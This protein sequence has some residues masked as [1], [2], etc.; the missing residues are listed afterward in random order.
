MASLAEYS[1]KK[2][3]KIV[4]TAQSLALKVCEM[5]T[6]PFLKAMMN[7]LNCEMESRKTMSNLG[8]IKQK[9]LS[10]GRR[11]SRITC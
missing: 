11:N 7:A 2:Q 5:I 1:H 9:V 6:P 8:Q 3:M 10:H 4:F